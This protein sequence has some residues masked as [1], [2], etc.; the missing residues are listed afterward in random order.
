MAVGQESTNWA[1]FTDF[2][3][4]L[5]SI[6]DCRLLIFEWMI[7]CWEAV[8]EDQQSKIVNHQSS[9]KRGSGLD[10]R[11]TGLRRCPWWRSS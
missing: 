3:L 5:G 11:A 7:D 8:A 10:A 9:I 1:D 6:D 4:R 2:L